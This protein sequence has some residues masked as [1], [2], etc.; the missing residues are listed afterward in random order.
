L[1]KQKGH[2]VGKNGRYACIYLPYHL[3]GL[4]TPMS[5]F[6]AVLLNQPTGS[7]DQLPHARMVA[8]AERDFAAGETLAMGGHHHTIQGAKPLLMETAKANDAAPFYL[9]ANKRLVADVK[10]GELVP[11]DALD[12]E[13]SALHAAWRRNP[14]L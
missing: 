11:L 2:V 13:G 5:I 10:A 6:S 12:L 7:A 14:S 1:L 3:M 8:R 4:E 9:A